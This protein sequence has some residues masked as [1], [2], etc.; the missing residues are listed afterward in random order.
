MITNWR[1]AA[2]PSSALLGNMLLRLGFRHVE[3]QVKTWHLDSR[4]PHRRQQVLDYWTELLLS[5]A[6]QLIEAGGWT[7]RW[8]RR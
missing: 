7:R 5:A 4:D 8:W 1:W 6:D 3:T 2:I